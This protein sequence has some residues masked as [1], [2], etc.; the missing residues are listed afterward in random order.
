MQKQQTEEGHRHIK[1]SIEK[2]RKDETLGGNTMS[3]RQYYNEVLC[4]IETSQSTI[5]NE[6]FPQFVDLCKRMNE[7]PEFGFSSTEYRDVLRSGYEVYF[8]EEIENG[9][10]KHFD[11]EVDHLKL[12]V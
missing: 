9:T 10:M 8:A 4:V 2:K 11:E 7:F 1:H 12:L 6:D 3:R 5:I